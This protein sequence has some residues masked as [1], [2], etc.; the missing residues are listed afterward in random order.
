MNEEG[1]EI[2]KKC[3]GKKEIIIHFKYKGKKFHYYEKCSHCFATGKID[4]IEK[5]RGKKSGICGWFIDYHP[6]GSMFV[7]GFGDMGGNSVYDGHDYIKVDTERGKALWYEL[8]T[9]EQEDY[10]DE[11]Q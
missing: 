5:A 6:A 7:N 3:K 9:K 2:C 4:W 10:D 8:I 11:I 1:Y